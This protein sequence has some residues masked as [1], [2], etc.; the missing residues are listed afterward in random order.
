MMLGGRVD[1]APSYWFEVDMGVPG[2]MLVRQV[3]G[4]TEKIEK[5]EYWE[6]GAV[7]AYHPLPGRRSWPPLVLKGV[8]AEDLSFFAWYASTRIEMLVAARRMLSIFLKRSDGKIM[9]NWNVVAAYPLSYTGPTFDVNSSAIAMES[10]E[11]T[12][13][14]IIRDL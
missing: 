14:G 7:A 4:L 9:A 6:G 11:L 8:V 12:H 2:L 5:K 1:P 10:I 3:Q 13:M